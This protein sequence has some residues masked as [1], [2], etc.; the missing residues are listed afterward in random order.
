MSSSTSSSSLL[1]CVLVKTAK[2]QSSDSKLIN[3]LQEQL[4]FHLFFL[5]DECCSY[6][7]LK[8]DNVKSTTTAVKGPQP[9]WEQ[10][11]YL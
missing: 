9:S 4:I 3:P 11:F 7:V 2:I 5:L 1:L 8:I 10:E 6:V